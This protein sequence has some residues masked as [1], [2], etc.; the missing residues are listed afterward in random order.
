MT[1]FYTSDNHFGHWTTEDRN[2]IKY[3]DRP[4]DSISEMDVKMIENW[5]NVVGHKDTVYHLGDF[6]F[7]KNRDIIDAIMD[8]LNGRKILISGNHDRD[9]IKKHKE[10][11]E[12]HQYLERKDRG[13]GTWLVMFHYPIANWNGSY[14]KSWHLHGHSHGKYVYP[15]NENGTKKTALDVGVDTHDFTPWSFDEIK[16]YMDN[17]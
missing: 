7:Y 10:W 14:H 2:I 4:F 9:Y 1:D 6:T 11:A 12:V 17:L 16:E 15:L 8:S 3:C 5:N 13:K